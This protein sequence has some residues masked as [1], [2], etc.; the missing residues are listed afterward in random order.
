MWYDYT[1]FPTYTALAEVRLYC[2][3]Q[4]DW[5]PQIWFPMDNGRNEFRINKVEM[6]DIQTYLFQKWRIHE[7]TVSRP[8]QAFV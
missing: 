3:I 4:T 2:N 7:T 5:G 1:H 8:L 6:Q